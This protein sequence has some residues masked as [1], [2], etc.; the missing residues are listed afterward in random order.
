[1][2][3]EPSSDRVASF[4][5]ALFWGTLLFLTILFL[6]L[7]VGLFLALSDR[8]EIGAWLQSLR[9]FLIIAL[10][11]ELT[12]FV[13]AAIAFVWRLSRFVGEMSLELSALS[14]DARETTRIARESIQILHRH[15]IQPILDL[16][17]LWIELRGVIR[18]W[19]GLKRATAADESPASAH[20]ESESN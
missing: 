9:D 5:R 2:S 18:A 19:A 16:R 6:I 17:A 15:L 10:L 8:G 4:G 7:G 13:V 14:G 1:M 12:L 20:A 11:L 3:V